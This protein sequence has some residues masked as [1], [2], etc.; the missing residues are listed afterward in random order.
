MLRSAGTQPDMQLKIIPTNM[1]QGPFQLLGGG[2]NG[3]GRDGCVAMSRLLRGRV[4][5]GY[6]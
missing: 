1:Q 2:R 4:H 5:H 6:G 3:H